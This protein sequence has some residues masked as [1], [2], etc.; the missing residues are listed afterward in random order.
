MSDPISS[1]PVWGL[2]DIMEKPSE[3]CFFDS[4]S[5]LYDRSSE[6][7][8]AGASPDAEFLEVLV[9]SLVSSILL[10]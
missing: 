9:S 8:W 7:V 2:L 3:P 5:S 10:V 4:L 1:V 6:E